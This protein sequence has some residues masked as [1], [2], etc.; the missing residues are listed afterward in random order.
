[1]P[2]MRMEGWRG[3]TGRV[4]KASQVLSLSANGLHPTLR[5]S[6]IFNAQWTQSPSWILLRP[7]L[8]RSSC[9]FILFLINLTTFA[10]SLFVVC[11]VVFM[12]FTATKSSD[13]F[14]EMHGKWTG[15]SD[16]NVFMLINWVLSTL[17]RALQMAFSII[18]CTTWA[19]VF[20]QERNLS[21]RCN[22]VT[23]FKSLKENTE[24]LFSMP[25]SILDSVHVFLLLHK[26]THF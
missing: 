10:S 4:S 1:M 22:S 21:F 14:A 6:D 25:Y 5:F 18:L 19:W 16:L 15:S 7:W 26:I 13:I 20:N 23:S 2:A 9:M 17:P 3:S 8:P 12:Y 11:P 24:D